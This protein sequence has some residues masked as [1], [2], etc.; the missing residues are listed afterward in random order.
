MTAA[1]QNKKV[2][3]SKVIIS[4]VL[5]IKELEFEPGAFTEVSGKNGQGKTSVLEA[6]KS[7]LEGGHDA[8]LLHNGAEKGEIVLVLDDD[9]T[10]TKR[11]TATKT[12]HIVEMEGH[13]LSSPVSLI[14][15]LADILSVNPI[16]F[17]RAPAKDRVDVLLEAMPMP[18]DQ[19]ALDKLVGF[20][21]APHL[22]PGMQA[23]DA[24]D[25]MHNLIFD[26]RTGSNR[27]HKDKN[28]TIKTL[29]ESLPVEQKDAPELDTLR[30]ELETLDAA[31]EAELTR[32]DE[33]QAG[34][35]SEYET[36]IAKLRKQAED[37][38]DALQNKKD[39]YTASKEA[40]NR[41]HAEKRQAVASKVA[42]AEEVEKQ[43]IRSQQTRDTI[44]KLEAEAAALLT[45][46]EN[47]SEKLD[48]LNEYKS[49]LLAKLP[50][51]G[52]EIIEG[53]V[54][55]NGIAFDRLNSAQQV[56]IAVEVAKL[57]SGKLGLI[58]VDGIELL[59]SNTYAEFREQA[60]ASGLQLVVARVTDENLKVVTADTGAAATAAPKK[61]T[62]RK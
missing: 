3:L 49:E 48:K 41:S 2:R 10:I 54:V 16:D 22:R 25:K 24:I 59:D 14:R 56:H 61:R 51:P 5:G 17:L 19:P 36:K 47:H 38:K 12:D 15:G 39:T 40:I 32:V 20:K 7:V 58:C 43:R 11:I 29:R 37:L 6:I 27:S 52:L 46:S 9:T 8:T 62:T 45:E 23:L 18:V 26:E 33:L 35:Q 57:R 53:G 4:N 13:K 50:I 60:V 30:A 21:V 31:R 42:A 55:Y 44:T 1:T 28:A 34:D